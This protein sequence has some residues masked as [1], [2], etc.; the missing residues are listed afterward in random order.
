VNDSPRYR[1]YVLG[2]LV[3]T[4]V[5]AWVDRNVFAVVLES[6]KAELELSDFSLGLL[7]GSAFGLFYATVGLPVAWLADRYHR[8]AV[9]ASAVALWSGM[10]ALCGL[11]TGFA[12]LFAAR[13]GVG[14]GE[15][16]CAPPAQSLVS[17]Y[18][19]PN[20]R[21]GALGVLYLYIPCGFVI[22]FL[23]GGWLNA[24]FGWRTAFAALGAPG[25]LLSAL[26]A[27]TLREPPRGRFDTAPAGV[28]P[29]LPSMLRYFVCSPALRQLPLAGAAHGVGA[30]AAAL[31][32]PA[33]LTRSF[34]L[35]S[36]E[37]GLWL[38]VAYGLGGGAG[39]LAGGRWA[40]A[41]VAR[42]QDA[43]WY[44]W[45]SAIVVLTALPF[46]AALYSTRRAAVALPALIIATTLWH[47]FLGP[48]T[49]AVQNLAGVRRRAAA[50]AFYLFLVNLLSAGVG[51]A[52]VGS[53]SD[54]LHARLGDDALGAALLGVVSVTGLWAASHFVWAARRLP[55]ESALARGAPG[56][57]VSESA[58][59]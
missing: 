46:C 7:G 35:S 13:V 25:L 41:L 16:G 10:T 28:A 56:L 8:S 58:I 1:R 17:D 59:P 53:I 2:L 9:I 24:H 55:A 37:A 47:M 26:V 44:A 4:G 51:P 39:V 11:A 40:D 52:L 49:A 14:I 42:T 32:L 38:A 18:F 12:S 27:L 50:A 6:I 45:G 23:G 43:R 3:L 5:V 29:S 57:E 22:G 36:G 20:R 21:A 19:A 33:Y 34:A 54:R 30:F 48:V 15:A 31:W